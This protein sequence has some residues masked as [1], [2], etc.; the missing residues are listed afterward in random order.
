MSNHEAPL[1]DEPNIDET[2]S[3][4]VPDNIAT[5]IL[6][7][8]RKGELP[9]W[10]TRTSYNSATIKVGLAEGETV[11]ITAPSQRL[12]EAKESTNDAVL[13]LLMKRAGGEE[14]DEAI[15]EEARARAGRAAIDYLAG[16]IT[17]FGPAIKFE[18]PLI[19]G[20]EVLFEKGA[21]IPPLSEVKDAAA[22]EAIVKDH[23]APGVYVQLMLGVQGL[24]IPAVEVFMATPGNA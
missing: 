17:E 2:T 21:P 14:V 6:D 1:T 7:G 10:M 18:R 16:V 5:R 3:P 9:P 12:S 24:S 19:V 13:E 23:L 20:D 15:L 4:D 11:S 22:R 8:F